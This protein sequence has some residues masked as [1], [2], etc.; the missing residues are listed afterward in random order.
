MTPDIEQHIVLMLGTLLA[1]GETLRRVLKRRRGRLVLTLSV[2]DENSDD[3][4]PNTR[5]NP[6]NGRKTDSSDVEQ[7]QERRRKD[8]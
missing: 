2:T 6:A 8:E 3:L 4:P 1:I 7:Q 5:Q